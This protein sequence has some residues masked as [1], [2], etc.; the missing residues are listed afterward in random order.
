MNRVG[1][2]VAWSQRTRGRR[3]AIRLCAWV[4]ALIGSLQL[5][6]ATCEALTGGRWIGIFGNYHHSA[7]RRVADSVVVLLLAAGLYRLSGARFFAVRDLLA[8]TTSLTVAFAASGYPFALIAICLAVACY[9][10]WT[11]D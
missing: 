9:L 8:F 3:W 1:A 6:D 5:A 2:L 7:L 11:L 4:Y 10:F